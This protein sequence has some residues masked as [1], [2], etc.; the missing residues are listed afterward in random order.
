[1]LPS[2]CRGG[3]L[4][5]SSPIISDACNPTL[6]VDR[7]YLEG[8]GK[9]KRKKVARRTDTDELRTV[10]VELEPPPKC[11]VAWLSNMR[12]TH[13]A[14]TTFPRFQTSF[15]PTSNRLFWYF[16]AS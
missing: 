16:G 7:L 3:R 10:L 11:H 12:A 5:V 2:P 14:Q 6:L 13:L 1:M 8:R 9:K 15:V 4:R